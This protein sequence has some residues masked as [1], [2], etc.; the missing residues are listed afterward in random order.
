MSEDSTATAPSSTGVINQS[1]LLHYFRFSSNIS[2][3]LCYVVYM[4]HK[5]IS[6][7]F[8]IVYILISACSHNDLCLYC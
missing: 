3:A 6:A 4:L 1:A 2:P 5:L 7:T 8:C